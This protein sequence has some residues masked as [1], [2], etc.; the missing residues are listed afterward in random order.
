MI[1]RIFKVFLAVLLLPV[2]ISA[3]LSLYEALS[4]IRYFSKNQAYFLAGVITYV[5]VQVL[6]YKPITLYVFGHELQHA[7][8][9]WLCGGKVKVFSVSK[10]GGKVAA[11]K[12]NTF[13]ALAPYLVPIYTALVLLV[14]FVLSWFFDVSRYT[15]HFIFLVGATLAFHI[16]LTLEVLRKGQSDVVKS[17]FIFS[18]VVIYIAN[19]IAAVFIL[20]LVFEDISMLR[21]FESSYESA[22]AI[23]LAIF[24]QLFS[25]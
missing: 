16:V 5:V 3:T 4:N 2:A 13:I 21:F 25:R 9:T 11:T 20:S 6:F 22:K 18:L 8:A 17:G 23:Y 10:K 19:I 7:L 12:S 14:Y 15:G 1:K 24:N